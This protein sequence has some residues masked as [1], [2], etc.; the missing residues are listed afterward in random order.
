MVGL[1]AVQVEAT[2]RLIKLMG[3]EN[4][5]L[6][7]LADQV[8]KDIDDGIMREVLGQPAKPVTNHASDGLEARSVDIEIVGE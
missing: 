5:A 2:S 3:E 7:H 8:A 4:R 1:E 6:S